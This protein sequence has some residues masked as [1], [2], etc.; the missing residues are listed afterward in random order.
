MREEEEEVEAIRLAVE[1]AEEGGSFK[2]VAAGATTGLAGPVGTS[3]LR[4]TLACKSEEFSKTFKRLMDRR[5]VDEGAPPPGRR[6]GDSP[7]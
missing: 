7:E 3:R 4:L 2:G 1:G 5:R 6:L